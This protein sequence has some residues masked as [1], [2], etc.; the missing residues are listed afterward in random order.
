MYQYDYPRPAVTVDCCVLA[1]QF[2]LLIER[3]KEPFRGLKALP[4]G[5]LNENERPVRGASRELFE[6]TGLQLQDEAL[7]LI[8]VFGDSTRDPRGHVIAIAY[9]AELSE[10]V[11]VLAGDDARAAGWYF[12]PSL[13]WS[14]FAFDHAQIIRQALAHS[15]NR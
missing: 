12:I 13:D 3:G 15:R 5:F 11:G 10:V 14:T 4:G 7:R 9:M 8:D 2:I 1:G 6:E